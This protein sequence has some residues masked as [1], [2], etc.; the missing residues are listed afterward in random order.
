MA[1]ESTSSTSI[2]VGSLASETYDELVADVA[3]CATFESLMCGKGVPKPTK[4]RASLR[5]GA[6]MRPPAKVAPFNAYERVADVVKACRE[7]RKRAVPG[8]N[9]DDIDDTELCKM[10]RFT[11]GLSL[12]D[13]APFLH[14]VPRLVNIVRSRHELKWGGLLTLRAKWHL[15][16]RVNIV[17]PQVTLAE[18]IPMH[19]SGLTLPLD[20]F[21][22]A[23]RCN[24]AYFASKRFAAVQVPCGPHLGHTLHWFLMLTRVVFVF[25]ARLHAPKV[26]R[27]CVP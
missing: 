26:P 12:Q 7:E 8:P 5:F 18:A 15:L 4:Q 25:A 22:I 10:A 3:A 19:G 1:Y 24:G 23:A 9:D 13:Y 27:P 14:Y 2:P 6:S 20:L 17:H 16:I 21:K 11:D